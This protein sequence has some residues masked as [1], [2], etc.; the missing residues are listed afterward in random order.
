MTI[1]I[2]LLLLL[3]S[4][5]LLLSNTFRLNYRDQI[6]LIGMLTVL[7]SISHAFFNVID[8]LYW[9]PNLY[10]DEQ[11]IVRIGDVLQNQPVTS[12]APASS[13][14]YYLER[15][16]QL[17]TVEAIGINR[18]WEEFV[19][20][21]PD[22]S[23]ANEVVNLQATNSLF[24]VLD[25][26]PFMGRMFTQTEQLNRERVV[27][28]SYSTWKNHFL[29]DPDVIGKTLYYGFRVHEIIG[30]MPEHFVAP[31]GLRNDT[32][33]AS[34]NLIVPFRF[35]RTHLN[36]ESRIRLSVSVFAKLKPG[37][38][39]DQL[40][41]E[42]Q[43]V[44]A[45]NGKQHPKLYEYE[46]E[47]GHQVIVTPLR[48]DLIRDVK[49]QLTL[50]SIVLTC[51]FFIC[52]MNLGSMTLLI[53]QKQ[54]RDFAVRISIGASKQ[55]LYQS[56][57]LSIF[58]FVLVC[59]ILSFIIYQA[60]IVRLV[61]FQ[62]IETL[63][64]V[65]PEFNITL[66]S[67]V[68]LFALSAVIFIILV[69]F[70]ILPFRS[71][72]NKFGIYLKDDSRTTATMNQKTQTIFVTTQIVFCTV[73]L[74]TSL[75][76][77]HSI[78]KIKNIK[79]GYDTENVASF[80]VWP[81]RGY[82][83]DELRNLLTS[84][85]GELKALEQVDDLGV[86]NF[87]PL[88]DVNDN[89]HENFLI[90]PNQL[91][92]SGDL[93]ICLTDLVD[94]GYFTTLN[95]ELLKGRYF[96]NFDYLNGAKVAIIDQTIASTYFANKDPIGENISIPPWRVGAEE[97]LAQ[98]SSHQYTIIGVVK[99]IRKK[100]FFESDKYGTVYV[101]PYNH[102]NL[103]WFSFVAKYRGD[104][105]TLINS[106]RQIVNRYDS[107]RR[108][109]A[110]YDYQTIEENQKR[111]YAKQTKVFGIILLVAI[112]AVALTMLSLFTAISIS[113]TEQ[114]KEFAIRSALGATQ[115]QLLVT[116][117]RVWSKY[118]YIGLGLGL[119]LSAWVGRIIERYLFEISAFD[120]FAYFSTIGLIIG[121]TFVT[122]A[123]TAWFG[124]TRLATNLKG[125]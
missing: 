51:V 70:A 99:N 24:E 86:V 75:L 119:L 81:R 13:Q 76:I 18:Y 16:E 73:V 8:S 36:P 58:K 28:L 123:I 66:R 118:C 23:N 14:I 61:E 29:S 111:H 97:A 117:T 40:E 11:R 17:T 27:V 80:A 60:T 96:N 93:P 125:L 72:S 116:L 108:P 87:P 25:I 121:L 104:R 94:D 50:F 79:V 84:L 113:I 89:S 74:V 53:S 39:I 55:Q 37:I 52:C 115:K 67:S 124:L 92:S 45:S 102:D 20:Y 100:K 12:S 38:S 59:L 31:P 43:L 15:E 7:L 103:S 47:H 56:I 101:N 71:L 120:S 85:R 30:V 42:L 107:S 112:L 98:A 1:F 34:I 110:F 95:I 62:G 106:V 114:R 90:L 54:L 82:A 105:R 64:L 88:L 69:C 19:S 91:S 32:N 109:L 77:A 22:G 10:Q 26:T 65:Q 44:A 63:F 4:N 6:L 41:R 57:I 3:Q 68:F 49:S 33:G 78:H 9:N 83:L 35:G 48:E 2:K 21:S 122:S 5:F 46:K